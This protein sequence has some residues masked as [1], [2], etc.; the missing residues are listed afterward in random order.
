MVYIYVL[1]LEQDKFYIGKTE[2]PQARINNHF[3]ENG[4]SWTT[5]YKPLRIIE[6][7]ENC[8]QYDEDKYTIK[9]MKQYGIENV[10]GGTF[11]ELILD[12][13]KSIVINEMISSS[14]DKCYTCNEFGHFTK[15]CKK[16]VKD[17]KKNVPVV[18]QN[19]KKMCKC[20]TSLFK[21]HTYN[22]C[23]LRKIANVILED[24]NENECKN[25]ICS[26]CG[27]NTH[28]IDK[29]Y[30]RTHIKGHKL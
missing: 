17:C 1:A 5:I 7:I 4:S 30:A 16:N 22:G 10:R 11:T 14:S 15:D 9:Y 20:P 24:E 25:N 12:E 18:I 26:R 6:L 8:D 23:A 3:I 21:A 13:S 28:T 29:C 2:N 27:R 19:K